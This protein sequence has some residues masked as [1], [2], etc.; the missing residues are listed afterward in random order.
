MRLLRAGRVVAP[1]LN[2][3]VMRR[4]K[5]HRSFAVNRGN[6]QFWCMAVLL[7]VGSHAEAH[8]S[9]ARFDQQRDVTIEGVIRNFEWANPHVYFHVAVRTDAGE[10][11]VWVVEAQ[12]PRVMSMFGWSGT[13]LRPGE[14]VT[15]AAHPLRAE[16]EPVALGRAVQKADGTT[17]KISWQPD[18]IREAIR[19]EQPRSDAR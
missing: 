7:L 6:L 9:P 13:S 8:H 3:G 2:C 19:R 18:E 15:I 14:F 17:F 4:P 12:S 1:P 16:G 11:V 5:Q 10:D